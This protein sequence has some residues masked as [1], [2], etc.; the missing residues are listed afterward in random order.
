M[1]FSFSNGVLQGEGTGC[2]IRPDSTVFYPFTMNTGLSWVMFDALEID[3]NFNTNSTVCLKSENS[4]ATINH[5]IWIFNS[6]FHGCGQSGMQWNFAD[7]LFV[8]HN[9]WHDNSSNSCVMGSGVSMWQPVGLAG[10]SPTI[11]NPDYWFT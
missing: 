1:P 7:W 3:G 8:I 4:S 5:H 9:V 2:V 10:Y 11:G 6:D